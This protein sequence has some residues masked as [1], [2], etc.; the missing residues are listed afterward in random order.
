MK[1][2]RKTSKNPVNCKTLLALAVKNEN[3]QIFWT[4]FKGV[5]LG[6]F[7]LSH[8]QQFT[9]TFYVLKWGCV[10]FLSSY[11]YSRFPDVIYFY[12]LF[13][14]LFQQHNE[15]NVI[16]VVQE[17]HIFGSLH[18]ADHGKFSIKPCPYNETCHVLMQKMPWSRRF[19][20]QIRNWNKN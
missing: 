15:D 14:F 16:F 1:S 8:H 12:V 5:M 4:D 3:F 11:I 6:E 9:V 17:N 20:I 19:D 13:V 10:C 18:D 2:L 7:L